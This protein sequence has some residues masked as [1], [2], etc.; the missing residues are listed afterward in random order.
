MTRRELGD[1][2]G[3]SDQQLAAVKQ[4]GTRRQ[5]ERRR[6]Q[7]TRLVTEG[8]MKRRELFAFNDLSATGMESG[9]G[10]VE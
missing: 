9:G 4:T 1:G 3:D 6:Q 7:G 5:P 10:G 2:K 8:R